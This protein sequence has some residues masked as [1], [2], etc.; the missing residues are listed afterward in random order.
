MEG[1]LLV[2]ILSILKIHMS[3]DPVF[4]LFQGLLSTENICAQNYVEYMLKS[5]LKQ[6][7]LETTWISYSKGMVQ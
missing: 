7:T 4:Y 2:Y 3:F 1:K 6:Q 5:C